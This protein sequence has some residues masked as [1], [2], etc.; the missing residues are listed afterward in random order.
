V[1][2]KK[3]ASGVALLGLTT[4]LGLAAL[5]ATPASAG[6]NFT[7]RPYIGGF[8]PPPNIALIGQ[9][10]VGHWDNAA[11]GVSV[12]QAHPGDNGKINGVVVAGH[13]GE[14]NVNEA[15]LTTPSVA[16]TTCAAVQISVHDTS[17][18]ATPGTKPGGTLAVTTTTDVQGGIS[19]SSQVTIDVT[20][21]ATQT[22]KTPSGASLLSGSLTGGGTARFLL[23]ATS[24]KT[25]AT[26]NT[27]CADNIKVIDTTTHDSGGY[28]IATDWDGSS[29]PGAGKYFATMRSCAD[30]GANVPGKATTTKISVV[31]DGS[32]TVSFV[33][34]QTESPATWDT[35]MGA[36]G[37]V[38][39]ANTGDHSAP[40]FGTTAQDQSRILQCKGNY[41]V[42]I[43]F[44]IDVRTWGTNGGED[45]NGLLHF[46]TPTSL[47]S[48][49]FSN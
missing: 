5:A 35:T 25:K 12:D 20:Y 11:C 26:L 41:G 21:P 33:E 43:P 37:V 14:L 40:T 36:C 45:P 15:T 48:A 49:S 16:T 28:P 29:I 23:K 18:T 7:I 27:S 24:V 44:A 1:R 9:T 32:D 4:G 31:G 42:A 10:D 34:A 19:A 47:G 3:L 38:K 8:N 13:S 6:T 46:G 22:L 17:V 39:T 2:L 30:T